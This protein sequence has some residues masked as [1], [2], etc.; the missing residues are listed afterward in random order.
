[1]LVRLD[2]YIAYSADNR[3]GI[4]ALGSL[5]SLLERQTNFADQFPP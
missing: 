4:A 2:G 5:R 3:D 1:M